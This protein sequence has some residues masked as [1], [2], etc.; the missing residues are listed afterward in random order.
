VGDK[1]C[2][3]NFTRGV[4]GEKSLGRNRRMAFKVDPKEMGGE[5]AR[6]MTR[7]WH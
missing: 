2:I 4:L 7:G 3:L 6:I 1:E 5:V